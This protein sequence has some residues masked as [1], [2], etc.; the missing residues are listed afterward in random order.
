MT[1]EEL[2]ERAAKFR[3]GPGSYIAGDWFDEKVTDFALEIRD[4]A[5]RERDAEWLEAI[6]WVRLSDDGI[7]IFTATEDSFGE[8]WNAALD[9]LK[10]KMED[11]R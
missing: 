8:G 5:V 3:E 2:I 1:R 6:D 9:R 7:T 4:E 11:K 10:A